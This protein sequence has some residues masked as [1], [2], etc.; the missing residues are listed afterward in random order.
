[1]RSSDK[2]FLNTAVYGVLYNAGVQAYHSNGSLKLGCSALDISVS[3]SIGRWQLDIQALSECYCTNNIALWDEQT[4]QWPC[5]GSGTEVRGRQLYNTGNLFLWVRFRVCAVAV[6]VTDHCGFISGVLY[7][8]GNL[9]I[10]YDTCTVV[11][12]FTVL[13]PSLPQLE[14][15]RQCYSPNRLD[16]Q[17]RIIILPSRND[18]FISPG[19]FLLSEPC[20]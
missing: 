16:L 18:Q 11:P 5:F 7:Q 6:Q 19:A 17:T 8:P 10:C 3:V 14:I 13:F 12:A 2:W 1:M 9:C 4:P 20:F 15:L